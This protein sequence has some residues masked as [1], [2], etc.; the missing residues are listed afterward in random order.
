MLIF[1]FSCLFRWPPYEFVWFGNIQQKPIPPPSYLNP[2]HQIINGSCIYLDINWYTTTAMDEE[3]GGAKWRPCVSSAPL[4]RLTC[5]RG[6]SFHTHTF[7]EQGPF[8]VA[9]NTLYWWRLQIYLHKGGGGTTGDLGMDGNLTMPSSIHR[10]SMLLRFKCALF[11][12]SDSL[13][14]ITNNQWIN[15]K[16]NKNA[17]KLNSHF[18]LLINHLE[19]FHPPSLTFDITMSSITTDTAKPKTTTAT[20]PLTLWQPTNC[21]TDSPNL[22]HLLP[23]HYRTI[24]KI[25]WNHKLKTT[26]YSY[27]PSSK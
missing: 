21:R 6:I 14:F 13:P 20:W 17:K 15:G 23:V 12:R 3:D 27:C 19:L 4:P 24:Y 8:R 1:Y 25:V 16:N 18:V 10:F 2:Q 5:L 22:E 26:L 9:N 7:Q 11:S